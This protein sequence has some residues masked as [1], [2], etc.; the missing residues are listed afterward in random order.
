MEN[1][2]SHELTKCYLNI[3]IWIHVSF[4]HFTSKFN[5]TGC[6]KFIVQRVLQ[7]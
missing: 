2:M 4:D 3:S 1:Q 6:H 7:K 5:L